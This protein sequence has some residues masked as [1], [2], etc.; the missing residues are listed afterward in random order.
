MGERSE[1]NINL[2]QLLAC[3]KNENQLHS[4][5]GAV[6]VKRPNIFRKEETKQDKLLE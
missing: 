2:Q 3:P 1:K 6:V 4:Y 5:L